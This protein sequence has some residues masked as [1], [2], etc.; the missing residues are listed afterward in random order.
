MWREYSSQLIL[1]NVAKAVIYVAAGSCL[2]GLLAL[3]WCAGAFRKRWLRL[4][5]AVLVGG[6]L[7][8]AIT[9]VCMAK[10]AADSL[11]KTADARI[12]SIRKAP[13]QVRVV[14]SKGNPV[15]GATVRVEQRRHSFLFGCNAFRFYYHHDEEN[16]LYAARFSALFNY[17]T[18]PFYW[19]LYE[20]EKGN[21]AA[22]DTIH[23]G[24][25]EWL[26]TNQIEAKG[27]PLVW[28]DLYPG[29]A[30]SDPDSA[31]EALRRRITTIIPEFKSEI[32]RW[33]VVN[34]A[35][36]A[37][38]FDNGV[39]HWAQRDGPASLVETAL[40]WAHEADPGAELVYNDFN[41]GRSH[42]RL[43]EQL[44]KNNASFQ[45]IGIQS[46]MHHREW[47]L[48]DVWKVC[49]DYS[50]FGKAIHFSEVT[51]LSGKHGWELPAPWP[52]TPEGEQRQADYVERLYTLLFSHP[53]VQAIT[54][55]DLQDGEWQGAPAG[56]LRADLTPKPA[57][58]RLLKLIHETWWTRESLSSNEK[59]VC[60]FVGFLGEY[61]V[62]VQKSDLSRTVK[63]TLA[64]G[65]N[66]WTV[67]LE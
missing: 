51:V 30:P 53:A 59:G 19:G 27:H 25:A 11:L 66:D 35:T 39:G 15:A 20:P 65:A 55:W 62:T 7:A 37:R 8:A 32:H 47:P 22:Y 33:D 41:V 36:V 40:R 63:R 42:R 38:C 18:L 50:K 10:A 9:Q 44:V 54:W 17:A 49:N 31:R 16:P 21:T 64:K 60:A 46:H 26:K 24:L 61:E 45:V 43:I 57:Y 5:C 56:L 3:L 29:W 13:A 23:K 4:G 28:H 2:A 48:E 1:L 67:V 58:D 12:A 14:D 52:T 34:E 6:L